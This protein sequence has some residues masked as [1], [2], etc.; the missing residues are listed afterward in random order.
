[1]T[2]IDA[3]LPGKFTTSRPL[4]RLANA[5]VVTIRGLSAA[6][7]ALQDWQDLVRQRRQLMGLSDAGLKDFGATRA[8]A[9]REG[10]KP[11]WRR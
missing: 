4:L 7:M 3:N 2:F 9:H 8:D 11:F 5:M 6:I 10:E 1:M